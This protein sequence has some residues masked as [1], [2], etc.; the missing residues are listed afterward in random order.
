MD[1]QLPARTISLRRRLMLA[2]FAAALITAA[3]TAYTTAGAQPAPTEAARQLTALTVTSAVIVTIIAAFIVVQ[4]AIMRL[5]HVARVVEALASGQHTARTGMKGGDEIGQ[6]G[7]AIDRYATRVEQKQDELR[8]TLRRHRR[9][10]AHLNHI[11]EALP[12]G[13][14]VLDS[15][16]C[17]TFVN[18]Q[19]K[20]WLGN[21]AESE[22]W[23]SVTAVVTDKLG[24]AI[25]PGLYALGDPRRIDM[26]ERVISA[27][28]AALIQNGERTG[29][30]IAMRDISDDVRRER[31]REA[32]LSRMAQEIENPLREHGRF[33]GR[34]NATAPIAN[35]AR[36]MNKHAVALHRLIAEMRDLTADSGARPLTT[37]QR[38]IALETLIWAVANE[39]RQIAQAANLRMDVQIE[40][41]GQYVLGDERRLRW[42]LGNIL[43]NAIKYTPPGGAIS[44]EIKSEE[45]DFARLRVRDN[46]TGI[47]PDDLPNVFTRFY[48]GTPITREGRTINVPGTGQ[49]LSVARQIVESTG[50]RIQVRSKVGVGTAVYLTLPLTAAEPLKL[51][52]LEG[53]DEETV[54]LS[55]DDA[56]S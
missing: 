24:A 9:E 50:G 56:L 23:Q 32:L 28:A 15:A 38:P 4:F 5:S 42:A 53:L 25:A 44:L 45:N 43:D 1:D 41:R 16:G 29:T 51:P 10:I 20:V 11:L 47:S 14:V 35:F 39:W 21:Q 55:V 19:A 17:V 34:A 52:R 30:V 22:D 48:R 2:F 46:G 54:Q 31:A 8:H 12:D 6:L 3:I 18:E 49:G 27:Q 36:E 7:A 40:Q 26:G 33:S 13:V 37:A